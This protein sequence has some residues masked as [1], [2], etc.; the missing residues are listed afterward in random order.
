MSAQ[1][2]YDILG[3]SEE[4]SQDEIKKAFRTLAHQYHPDKNPDSAD[5]ENMFKK[6][7]EAYQVLSDPDKRKAYDASLVP[8]TPEDEA[9]NFFRRSVRVPNEQDIMNMFVRRLQ[10]NGFVNLSF[11][12]VIEGCQKKIPVF[13][14]E[15]SFSEDK[16]MIEVKK[17]GVITQ[18]LPPG[19]WNGIVHVEADFDGKKELLN[20]QVGL[21]VPDGYSVLR[22]GD[23][24]QELVLSYPQ[25]ILGGV[26]SV[27]NLF[28]EPER[29]S[30]PA[31]TH[32]GALIC[33][34]GQGLPRAPKNSERGNLLYSVSVD[35][36]E[37][38]DEETK[39]ILEQLQKK[40]EQQSSKVTS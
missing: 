24:V 37:E 35:I 10:T 40:L 2:Y 5:A 9:F 22:G 13:F 36:P 30:V 25:S 6:V 32:P 16:K 18:S 28:G 15:R 17:E 34:K 19:L 27:K 21:D 7:N 12:E 29:L 39:I 14:V 33:V 4:S 26:V 3:I 31:N 23:V 11:R 20:I 1:N 38:V 8:Q